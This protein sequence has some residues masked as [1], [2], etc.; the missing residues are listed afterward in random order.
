M[1]SP[2]PFETPE[3]T[4][5]HLNAEIKR[6]DSK[7]DGSEYYTWDWPQV[8]QQGNADYLWRRSTSSTD[9]EWT[10]GDSDELIWSDLWSDDE[11]IF[12]DSIE[13]K[14]YVA[15]HTSPVPGIWTIEEIGVEVHDAKNFPVE[16]EPPPPPP[17]TPLELKMNLEHALAMAR[18]HADFL[19]I[20]A[21][22]K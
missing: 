19:M 3:K 11:A 17:P 9:P 15:K 12:F 22:R 2:S 13:S 8:P 4:I 18:F 10:L 6:W 21:E 16:W 5:V 20:L 7:L 1:P 14:W